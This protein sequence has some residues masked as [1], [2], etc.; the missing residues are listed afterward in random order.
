MCRK[1]SPP[2]WRA[3]KAA[4]RAAKFGYDFRDV[5]EAAGK[6]QEELGELLAA[7]QEK[8]EAHIAEEAGGPALFRRQC[9]QA[10]GH[11]LRGMPAGEHEQVYRA[12]LPHR[13]A[14]PRG[15][16]ADAG[17]FGGGAL[18]VL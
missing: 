10:C 12:F 5:R 9:W 18:G 14:H 8:D 16:K 1:F 2:S 15:R 11:R 4:K 7:V 3:Q 6:V 13:T 17:P